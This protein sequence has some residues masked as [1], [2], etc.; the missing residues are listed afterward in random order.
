[1]NDAQT[2]V[3][4]GGCFWCTGAVFKGL[5]GVVDVESG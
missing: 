3:L 2:L 4:G 5:R 1:M